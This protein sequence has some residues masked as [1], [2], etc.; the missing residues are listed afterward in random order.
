MGGALRP[1]IRRICTGDVWVRSNVD[2]AR[3]GRRT[4]CPTRRGPGGRRHVERLEVVPVGLDL[5]TLG[6]REAHADEDVLEALAG[7]GDQV[8]VAPTRPEA[9]TVSVRSRRSAAR[10]TALLVGHERAAPVRPAA[11][12]SASRASCTTRSPT[13]GAVVRAPARRGRRL[14]ARGPT[15]CRAASAATASPVVEGA[16]GRHPGQ[17][18]IEGAATSSITIVPFRSMRRRWT[19]RAGSGARRACSTRPDPERR[20]GG[21][22]IGRDSLARSIGGHVSAA[23]GRLEAQ[24]ARRPCPR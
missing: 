16:D 22:E 14:N 23:P 21:D 11:A 19:P 24:D 10:T 6:H 18:G 4:G 8:E 3:P 9:A 5:G 1:A 15:A 13:R 20:P 7:L 17:R 2:P 12:S